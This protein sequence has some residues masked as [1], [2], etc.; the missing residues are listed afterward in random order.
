MFDILNYVWVLPIPESEPMPEPEPKAI[1]DESGE[2]NIVNN[3]VV[4]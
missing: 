2:K 4:I 3:H 1:M